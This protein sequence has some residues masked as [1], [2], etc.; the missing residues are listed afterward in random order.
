MLPVP[1]LH[2]KSLPFLQ[3]HPFI[4]NHWCSGYWCSF[5]VSLKGHL[6]S[7]LVMRIHKTFFGNNSLQIEDR[8]AKLAPLCLSLRD[9]SNDMQHDITGSSR[10][11]DLRSNFQLD[12]LRS[13]CMSF[14]L[15]W[16]GEHDAVKIISL[17]WVH[18]KLFRKFHTRK[19]SIICIWMTSGAYTTLGQIWQHIRDGKF[20][21][22]SSAFL[23][24]F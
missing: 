15:P 1:R 16:C 11:L 5:E 23:D 13:S 17:P 9:A 21:W 10:D 7:S 3:Y 18:K 19:K 22:P 4:F 2:I 20:H 14:E 12:L 8:E 6:R 24:S